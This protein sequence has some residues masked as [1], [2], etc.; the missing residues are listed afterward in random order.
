MG[1]RSLDAELLAQV[2]LEPGEHARRRL[3][4][5]GERGPPRR[6]CRSSRRARRG[7]RASGGGTRSPSASRRAA[8]RA[9]RRSARSRPCAVACCGRARA[10]AG[11]R[12]GSAPSAATTTRSARTLPRGVCSTSAEPSRAPSGAA[13][14][15]VLEDAR[16]P[17]LGAVRERAD[18][19][20]R[21]HRAVVGR[22]VARAARAAQLDRQVVAR[23][24]ARRESRPRAAPRCPPAGARSP[25]SRPRAG[26]S[27]ALEEVARAELLGDREHLALGVDRG[28]VDP[29]ARARARSAA[30]ASLWNGAV[31]AITKPPLRPLAPEPAVRASSTVARHPEPRPGARRSRCR[32]R[33]PPITQTST[34]RS[35]SSAAARRRSS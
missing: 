2:P 25:R 19:A 17:R 9:A 31:P 6:R 21:L 5:L 30:R 22:D 13:T 10:T 3:L 11:T 23:R 4:A 16:A 29:C 33:P 20:C 7:P 26:G 14:G 28:R 34:S 18:P 32:R 1:D 15:R 8:A 24:R 12:I 27:R 35:A